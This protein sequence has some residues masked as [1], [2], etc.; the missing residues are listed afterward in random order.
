MINFINLG[1]IELNYSEI[2]VRLTIILIK[3]KY[4]L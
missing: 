1:K 2:N 4:Q 3:T